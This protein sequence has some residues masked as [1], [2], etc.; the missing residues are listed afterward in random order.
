M[1][2]S[3]S[4][5]RDWCN[6]WV[7]NRFDCP[8]LGSSRRC[9]GN[10]IQCFQLP[11]EAATHHLE[12]NCFPPFCSRLVFA[13][14]QTQAAIQKTPVGHKERGPFFLNP[15]PVFGPINQQVNGGPPRMLGCPGKMDQQLQQA[16]WRSNMLEE[17][18][19]T[20]QCVPAPCYVVPLPL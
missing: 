6:G 15:Q 7:G 5:C 4:F 16:K 18:G 3:K 8:K 9:Q 17:P 10:P 1:L 20:A 11:E 19:A 2:Q 12:T 13:F 14:F